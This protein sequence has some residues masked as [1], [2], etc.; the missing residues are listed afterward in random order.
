MRTTEKAQCL[1]TVLEDSGKDENKA[2][3]GG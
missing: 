2:V 3:D 1:K